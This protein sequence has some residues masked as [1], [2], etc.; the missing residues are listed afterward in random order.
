VAEIDPLDRRI[1]DLLR[2]DGRRTYVELA[3]ELG[4]REGTIRRRVDQLIS[5]GVIR[6][7]ARLVARQGHRV[8]VGLR[9][10]GDSSGI[11][12]EVLAIPHLVRAAQVAGV[13]DWL[14]WIDYDDDAE[15]LEIVENQVRAL[16]GVIGV[17][18]IVPL[19]V[20]RDSTSAASVPN[21]RRSAS[22][23]PGPPDQA[24]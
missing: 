10:G 6:I 9:I 21:H 24:R 7:A 12:S 4:V 16:R 13:F 22:V 19:R 18:I 20:V 5:D 2:V 23:R 1:I 8:L 11:A 3:E 14:L 17:E 15:L